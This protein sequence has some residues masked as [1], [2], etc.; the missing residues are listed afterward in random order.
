[1]NFSEF[2]ELRDDMIREDVP[3][4]G[5]PQ[6]SGGVGIQSLDELYTRKEFDSAMAARRAG[7]APGLD[8]VSYEILRRVSGGTRSFV[9]SLFNCILRA[10]S[11]P[12]SWWHTFVIFI[13]KTGGKGYRP[14]SLTSFM[15]KLFERMVHQRLEHI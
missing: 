10:S 14:I 2:R 8:G 11:F 15:N 4:A 12:S 1:M 9:L 6:R 3:L 7:S 13:P 5:I